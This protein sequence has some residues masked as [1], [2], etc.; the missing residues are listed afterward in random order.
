[1]RPLLFLCAAL[2]FALPLQAQDYPTKLITIVVPFPPGG[3]V[4]RAGRLMGEKLR[5]RWGQPVVIENRP[6][7]AANIGAAYVFKAPPD[8]HTLLFTSPGPL[9][10]NKTMFANLNYD[11]DQFVPVTVL[12]SGANM[13]TVHPKVGVN[14]LQ[15]FLAY[16]RANPGKLNYGT[17]GAGST[18]HLATELLQSSAGIS[19][20]HVPYKGTGPAVADLLAGSV[21]VMFLEYANAAPHVR[22]G[23]LKLIAVGSE[24]RHPLLPDVPALNEV[25]PGFSSTNWTAVVAPPGTPP[26]IASKLSSTMAEILKQPDVVKQ[27]QDLNNDPIGNTPEQMAAFVRQESA[28]WSEVIRKAGIKAE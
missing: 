8:G 9:V 27:L 21:E 28:R 26:A 20:V 11:P 6:G 22:A 25:V 19:M 4:D 10:V 17:Q 15:E 2:L 12:M 1:M 7:A 5:E 24:K 3:G 13:L 14:T 23:R 18:A 16:A